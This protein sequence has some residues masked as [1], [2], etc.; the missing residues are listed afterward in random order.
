M[1]YKS[2]MAASCHRKFPPFGG[3]RK[4]ERERHEK[5]SDRDGAIGNQARSATAAE[6][7]IERG[8][9]AFDRVAG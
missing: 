7:E 6:T 8:W 3:E 4:K 2:L 9:S 5:D 1:P